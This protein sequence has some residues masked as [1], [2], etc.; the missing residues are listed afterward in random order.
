MHQATLPKCLPVDLGQTYNLC[1]TPVLSLRE[2]CR[3]VRLVWMAG[4]FEG[5]MTDQGLIL[6][7]GFV[8]V[9]LNCC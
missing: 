8:N 2:I 9:L 5:M 6:I 4:S 7:L 3:E 1:Q